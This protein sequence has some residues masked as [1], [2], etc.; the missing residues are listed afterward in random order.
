MAAFV[1]EEQSDTARILNSTWTFRD[2]HIAIA[3]WPP[4]KSLPEINLSKIKFWIQAIGLPISYTNH[5]TAKL[6]GDSIGSFVKADLASSS[7]RW[8]KA[9][10]IQ[11][12]V[13]LFQKL[14]SAISISV[15]GKS[16]IIAE[17]RYERL[18][19]F[20]YHCGLIGHRIIICDEAIN[21]IGDRKISEIY[22][23]WLKS[24]N[25]HI[26]NPKFVN[27][28]PGESQKQ[29]TPEKKKNKGTLIGE[30]PGNF[31]PH[32]PQ[33]SNTLSPLPVT[34]AEL[35]TPDL[36]MVTVEQPKQQL[37][38]VGVKS[39][40]ISDTDSTSSNMT[41]IS[42]DTPAARKSDMEME[43]IILSEERAETR[44]IINMGLYPITNLEWALNEKKRNQPEPMDFS[45][46]YSE[47]NTT[48]Y[49]INPAQDP[50]HPINPPN[51]LRSHS[52]IITAISHFKKPK[53]NSTNNHVLINPYT[54]QDRITMMKNANAVIFKPSASINSEKARE[55]SYSISRASGTP[56]LVK[57]ETLLDNSNNQDSEAEKGAGPEGVI[58]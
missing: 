40:K 23:P 52:E 41:L 27:G 3:H 15:K 50:A 22:G 4:D 34:V 5:D 42:F 38:H 26:Q 2:H 19:E 47:T 25:S 48:L 11:I 6:I 28:S 7:A 9:L 55:I 33:T 12:E 37:A 58:R 51:N 10:R 18:T 44:E 17:I 8:K 32:A 20:C 21:H 13:D 46:S 31:N 29:P 56:K 30:S 24:D 57:V 14:H 43:N 16:K 1:F 35:A 36:A 49:Q 53:L 45:S 39:Q 54:D